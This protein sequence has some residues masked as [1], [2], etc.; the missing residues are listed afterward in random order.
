[1]I[2]H[3][4]SNIKKIMKVSIEEALDDFLVKKRRRNELD[5]IKDE[6]LE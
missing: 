6:Q 2:K 5:V 3:Y 1:M 4:F